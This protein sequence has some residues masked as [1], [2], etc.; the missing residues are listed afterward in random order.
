VRITII[1]ADIATHWLLRKSDKGEQK[2]FS[3][4][5]TEQSDPSHQ[6][7]TFSI[8]AQPIANRVINSDIRA[9]TVSFLALESFLDAFLPT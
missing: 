5:G 9:A 4:I 6:Y 2:P 8:S 7:L 3:W 1:V